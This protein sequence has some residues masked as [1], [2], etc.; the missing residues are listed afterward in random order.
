MT[1]QEWNDLRVHPTEV[2]A[3]FAI[4]WREFKRALPTKCVCCGCENPMFHATHAVVKDGAV[5]AWI[6]SFHCAEHTIEEAHEATVK[7]WQK[8]L[9]AE[10]TGDPTV[11]HNESEEWKFVQGKV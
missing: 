3:H 11:G 5:G 8:F 1:E 6:L 4:S 2:P 7:N 9:D 10:R